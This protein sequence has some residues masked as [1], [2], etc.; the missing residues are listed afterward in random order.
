MSICSGDP[1]AVFD[2]LR[3]TIPY[4][5]E[6]KKE[7]EDDTSIIAFQSMLRCYVQS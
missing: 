2:A 1:D 6:D 5:R 3:I 7:T 4:G